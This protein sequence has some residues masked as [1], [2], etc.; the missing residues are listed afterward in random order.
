MEDAILNQLREMNERLKGI[1]DRLD[2]ADNSLKGISERLSCVHE[3]LSCVG[4][5]LSCMSERLSLI[6][7]R[8]PNAVFIQ[9]N[10]QIICAFRMHSTGVTGAKY[11]TMRT[12]NKATI[13]KKSGHD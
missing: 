13:E 11:G 3:R 4:E 1:N 8:L 6:M 10:F 9:Q 2:R 7:Q 5:R 12:L